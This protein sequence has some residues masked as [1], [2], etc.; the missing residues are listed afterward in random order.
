MLGLQSL[1]AAGAGTD[2]TA[3]AITAD[4]TPTPA[5]TGTTIADY[6]LGDDNFSLPVRRRSKSRTGWRAQRCYSFTVFLA[7]DNA[8][9]Q[10]FPMPPAPTPLTQ[11]GPAIAAGSG[12]DQPLF[13][14]GR[15]RR[16]KSW[17]GPSTGYFSTSAYSASGR[18]HHYQHLLGINLTG[19][20]SSPGPPAAT[21]AD[22]NRSTM[23]CGFTSLTKGQPA[24]HRVCNFGLFAA[25][26]TAAP[27]CA[28]R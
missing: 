19:C 23:G 1:L 28:D 13:W 8:A 21:K 17:R 3:F 11:Y 20:D 6:A 10:A 26:H 12:T 24:D 15:E 18:R 27:G 16:R 22:V 5:E 14:S 9:F 7:P 2:L 25:A 4:E